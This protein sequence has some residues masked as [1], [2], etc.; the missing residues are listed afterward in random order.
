MNRPVRIQAV[1]VLDGF[2]VKLTFTDGSSRAVNL[3]PFLRGPVFDEIR[4]D[5]AVFRSVHVDPKCGTIVWSN[6]ADIDPDV[7]Y[8][9]LKPAWADEARGKLA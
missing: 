8:L 2:R 1:R 9:G 6:G 4:R 7:L 3:E 5:T